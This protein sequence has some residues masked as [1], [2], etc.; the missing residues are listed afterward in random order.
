MFLFAILV[1]RVTVKW[2]KKTSPTLM[3]M[4]YFVSFVIL[5]VIVYNVFEYQYGPMNL[6]DLHLRLTPYR[7]YYMC[8]R[9]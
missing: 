6:Q 7:Q 4:P 5:K 1:S 3:F 2:F 9:K 8:K